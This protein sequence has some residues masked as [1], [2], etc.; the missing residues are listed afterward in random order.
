[1]ILLAIVARNCESEISNSLDQV[2]N[3]SDKFSEIILVNNK[4]TDLT[5]E[6]VLLWRSINSINIK[7]LNNKENYGLG[8]SHKIIFN[9][10]KQHK[11]KELI[12]FHG[13]NQTEINSIIPYLGCGETY[14]GSRFMINSKVE[15]YS[16]FRTYLNKLLNALFSI[17][18]G[19]V[20]NDMG[21]GLNLYSE[22]IINN[23]EITKY[24]D[25]M[26]FNYYHLVDMIK[27]K[28]DIRWFPISWKETSSQS[29]MKFYPLLIST[30][31]LYLSPLSIHFGENKE[32][33]YD[34]L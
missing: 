6:K 3:Y 10:A 2:K 9:Y 34:V 15:N 19:E 22:K 18:F 13:D 14:L 25:D 11:F 31:K 16:N 4:S 12:I 5:L 23:F 7:I 8:G 21:S 24:P 26:S 32:M 1:M 27:L 20:I 17:R 28:N 33:T 29:N 30:I